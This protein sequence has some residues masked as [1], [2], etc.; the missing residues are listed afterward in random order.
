MKFKTKKTATESNPWFEVRRSGVHG[1]GGFAIRWIPKGTRII[2]YKG[3]R[4]THD[5]ADERYDDD[6][7]DDHHTFLFTVDEKIVIDATYQGNE[8]RFINHSCDPNCE[9]V[10]ENG[11][12]YIEAIRDIPP[13]TELGYDYS[14]ERDEPYQK[15]W[16]RLY[17]CRCGSPSCRGTMLEARPDQ[18]N[19]KGRNKRTRVKG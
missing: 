2:E 4:I 10:I 17:A 8:A 13:G 15:E 16:E 6:E 3:Q 5:Q 14:L 1:Y 12:V 18:K 7:M 19:Q 9:S 11:R